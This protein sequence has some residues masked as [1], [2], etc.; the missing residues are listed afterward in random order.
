MVIGG[1]TMVKKESWDGA[2]SNKAT[3]EMWFNRLRNYALSV[4]EWEGL[5]PSINVR[6][7][8]TQLLT[9]GQVVF[10]EDEH[11]GHLALQVQTGGVVN[12]YMEPTAYKAV[13][14]NYNKDLTPDDSVIIYDNMD[15]TPRLPTLEAY[16][17]R[18]F[19]VEKTMDVNI[20][21][22]KFPIVILTD[23]SQRLT[24][25]NAMQQYAGNEPFIWG[26]KKG[27]DPE[28]VRVIETGAPFV[29]DKLM[30]Y[31]HNLWNEAMTFLGVGNSKQ[32]KTERMVADEVAANDEQ[33]QTSRHVLLET[34]QQ[35]C[36]QI[37]KMF[38]LNVSVDFKLN[39]EKQ[40]QIDREE[41]GNDG[42]G[43]GN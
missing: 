8:E 2:I 13:S 42:G 3:Y 25:M 37:N 21:S 34:R 18:L 36:E 38:G 24:M 10:F 35:A 27:F 23:E 28:S 17:Q 39:I 14:F 1:Y 32:D 20:N 29:T 41:R 19:Q 30:S 43:N 9:Y 6:Y 40:E 33:I 11:I 26:N 15:R 7:L 31:K 4:F 16:A 12:H 22:Q 5:P